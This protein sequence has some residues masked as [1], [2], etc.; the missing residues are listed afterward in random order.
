MISMSL[1]TFLIIL[2]THAMFVHAFIYEVHPLI[3]DIFLHVS[4]SGPNVPQTSARKR[5][6][7]LLPYETFTES[8]SNTSNICISSV[9]IAILI[10]LG[11]V[12]LV[13]DFPTIQRGITEFAWP[14]IHHFSVQFYR[15]CCGR[16]RVH[17]LE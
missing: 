5:R 16:D 7:E 4:L 3:V 11:S 13:L 15:R 6:E 9:P 10:V 1:E 8:D 2:L 12:I 14:R 17:H